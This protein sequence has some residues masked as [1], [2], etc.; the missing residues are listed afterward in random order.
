MRS[1]NNRD[2]RSAMMAPFLAGLFH[3]PVNCLGTMVVD[4]T[5][6][7]QQKTSDT[8]CFV[9]LSHVSQIKHLSRFSST[10]KLAYCQW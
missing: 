8:S 2:A 4:S 5:R 10:N 6:G 3:S 1:M 9:E 7:G